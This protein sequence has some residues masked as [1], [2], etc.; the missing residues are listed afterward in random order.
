MRTAPTDRSAI[1]RLHQTPWP[2]RSVTTP[3]TTALTLYLVALVVE[4]IGIPAPIV[5][6]ACIFGMAVAPLAALAAQMGRGEAIYTAITTLVSGFW[7][8]WVT[9]THTFT[10]QGWHSGHLITAIGMLFVGLIAV[11]PF[12]GVLRHRRKESVAAKIVEAQEGKQQTRD[13]WQR[14]F[15]EAGLP[16]ANIT[17]EATKFGYRLTVITE[18]GAPDPLLGD[19]ARRLERAAA[20]ILAG[21]QRIKR[22]S[23]SLEP[24]EGANEVYVNVDTADHLSHV[25]DMDPTQLPSSIL[26]PIELGMYLTGDPMLLHLASSYHTMIVG[27]TGSGKSVLEN[28]MLSRIT[29]CTDAVVWISATDKGIPLLA[30]WLGP[31]ADGDT[32]TPLFDW[33]SVDIDESIKMLL[34]AYKLIDIRS[35][36]PRN[37]KSKIDISPL[38]PALILVLEEA[39]GILTDTR[40]YKAHNGKRMNASQILAEITRLGRSEGVWVVAA[41][42]YGTGEMLGPEGPKMKVN[43]GAKIGL[44]TSKS[45]ENRYVFPDD[46]VPLHLLDHV[47]SLYLK[48]EKNSHIPESGRPILG[49]GYHLEDDM[50]SVVAAHNTRFRPDLEDYAIARLG[51]DYANRWSNDRAGEILDRIRGIEPDNREEMAMEAV[52]GKPE[53]HEK[54][55]PD[56]FP[57]IPKY[58]PPTPQ[59]LPAKPEEPGSFPKLPEP[60][61]KPDENPAEKQRLAEIA[62]LNALFTADSIAPNRDHRSSSSGY[63]RMLE[64]VAASGGA[65]IGPQ[66]IL[67][68]LE[69]DGLAP[70]RKTVH[71]WLKKAKESGSIRQIGTGTYISV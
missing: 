4:L 69:S 49:R 32:T 47:G 65:G 60:Y 12:F 42:Q 58:R 20:A 44:K 52:P 51:E 54:P 10:R 41:A 8:S 50:V 38:T 15:K 28:V 18:P 57:E 16:K 33:V 61:R 31:W 11:G 70:S 22:G 3:I 13:P 19:T 27:K 17:C 5:L 64:I 45:D 59:P 46:S 25:I 48:Q 43:F 40:T 26:L 62:Q 23:I 7:M 6:V 55:A 1:V 66:G 9:F 29:S 53:A 34:A 63:E 56:G 21:K 35:R 67:D 24:G 71:Q 30:P 39:P 36:R 68:A 37:R 14:I 2:Y